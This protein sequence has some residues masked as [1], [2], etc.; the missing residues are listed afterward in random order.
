MN[1]CVCLETLGFSFGNRNPGAVGARAGLSGNPGEQDQAPSCTCLVWSGISPSHLPVA[2]WGCG[3]DGVT[4]A[5]PEGSC[6]CHQGLAWEYQDF[7]PLCHC[8]SVL[9]LCLRVWFL[10]LQGKL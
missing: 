10:V 6:R 4:G 7:Q 8:S 1:N 9:A 3:W 2:P 5:V